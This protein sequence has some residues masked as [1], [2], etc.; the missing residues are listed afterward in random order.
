MEF[1]N[2]ISSEH[3]VLFHKLESV[4]KC[5]KN[6]SFFTYIATFRTQLHV[7]RIFRFGFEFKF[8]NF[9]RMLKPE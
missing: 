2:T 6:D 9:F 1:D 7:D 8:P 4:R 3:I 5:F